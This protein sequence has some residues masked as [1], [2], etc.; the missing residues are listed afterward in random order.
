MSWKSYILRFVAVIGVIFLLIAAVQWLPG[1]PRSVTAGS[2]IWT[3]SMHPQIRVPNPGNCPI[4]GMKLIPVSQLPRARD[5]LETRAGLVTE[6]VKRRELHKE[7]RAVGK[8]D[9]S[10]RQV[11]YISARID[12]RVD[13]LFVD[14]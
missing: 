10:E 13:R 3:C 9:Y 5:E 6:P 7:I 11:E 12:G 14:F 8:L 2:D 1:G 4:C